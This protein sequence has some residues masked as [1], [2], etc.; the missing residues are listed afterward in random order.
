ME[1]ESLIYGEDENLLIFKILK[2]VLEIVFAEKED[3]YLRDT[4]FDDNRDYYE[5]LK[6]LHAQKVE[7]QKLKALCALSKPFVIEFSGTSRT[8]K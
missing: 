4:I 2:N 3:L 8:V 6:K 7:L 1:K 5:E